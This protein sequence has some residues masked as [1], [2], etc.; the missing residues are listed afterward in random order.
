[1]EATG[2]SSV[3][4][5]ERRGA[6]RIVSIAA[7]LLAA[8]LVLMLAQEHFGLG[9]TRSFAV[10]PER[11]RE[12]EGCF[13]WALPEDYR[14]PL[15]D[16][17]G[18][19][20][21]DGEA[22]FN[23]AAKAS[24]ARRLGA[25]WWN[26]HAGALRFMPPD[27]SDPRTNGHRYTVTLPAR[28][29]PRVLW[30]IAAL[31]VACLMLRARFGASSADEP[32]L[33]RGSLLAQCGVVFVVTLAV[34][35]A[36]VL[37]ERDYCDPT[38]VTK[39]IADSDA[40]GW[41][42]MGALLS[43]GY[44]L[45]RSGF[46]GQRPMHG[47]MLAGVMAVFGQ[48]TLVARLMNCALFALAASGVWCLGA[49]LRSRWVSL[50]LVAVV[51][52][53]Q[54]RLSILHAV[55]TENSGL[56][57]AVVALLITW[58]A[59]WELSPRWSLL[60]GI[61]HG[62]G[63]LASGM[64]L[65]ALPF[66]TL[67]VLVNP[68]ARRAPWRLAALMVVMFVAGVSVV[69]L[70]W[71]TRQKIVFGQFTLSLNTGE[72]LAGAA[73]PEGR[74]SPALLTEAGP[75]G[76]NLTDPGERYLYFMGRFKEMVAADPGAYLRHV[77]RSFMGAFEHVQIEDPVFVLAGLLAALMPAL[78]AGL[79]GAG[80]W[81]L[82]A[83]LAVMAAWL[84][85]RCEH[86]LPATVALG[87]FAWRRARWPEERL[88]L[89]LL[90]ATIAGLAA[91]G[92]LTGNQVTKRSWTTADWAVA[93]VM[94]LG[95]VRLVEAAGGFLRALAARTGALRA[96][97]GVAVPPEPRRAA[98]SPPVL[99]AFAVVLVSFTLA[100]LG[101]VLARSTGDTADP[102]P[103]LAEFDA[104]AA[105]TALLARHPDLAG[106]DAARFTFRAG[107]FTGMTADM[108]KWEATGNWM[109]HC[110]PR[111]FAR[112]LAL[113]R[114]WD[115][116]RGAGVILESVQLSSL[117]PDM[118]R[119]E[120]MLCVIVPNPG[121]NRLDNTPQPVN[122]ALALAP[123]RQGADGRWIVDGAAA[124]FIKPTPEAVKTLAG[125]R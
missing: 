42:E 76:R 99:R 96:F 2:E 118:P 30:A 65:F 109:P 66:Y 103:G 35:C 57:F 116:G 92:G 12:D 68:L 105:G 15:M 83:A 79:R 44:P 120:P 102:F 90:F 107:A 4:N 59:A 3:Q 48:H 86:V 50:A 89:A 100:S 13:R 62:L 117:P 61:T 39:D 55:L 40:G 80:G 94:F 81:H 23:R 45:T 37:V 95:L 122:E 24:E 97:A 108:R 41:H 7:W 87:F 104:R 14:V 101:F 72:V 38:F 70:P 125:A 16:S 27:G 10:P 33:S 11:L 69:F 21:E 22:V 111:P 123:L 54:D 28:V 17:R 32:P 58:A 36:R 56:A 74:L 8:A 34:L 67:V 113:M 1:M 63:V 20:A 84:Q 71:M 25:S 73:S 26:I 75:E 9:I 106:Q 121:T 110:Q 124:W 18:E 46:S 82:L 88:A 31:L 19:L 119:H 77:G 51:A 49:L 93:A 64:T 47:V 43:E 6:G 5:V 78:A 52:W 98:D 91:L 115:R 53:H 85:I 112:T 29:E 60:A 114:W